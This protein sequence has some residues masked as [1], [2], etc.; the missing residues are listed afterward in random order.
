MKTD[1]RDAFIQKRGFIIYFFCNKNIL[2][3]IGNGDG[4]ILGKGRHGTTG[5]LNTSE[6]NIEILVILAGHAQP[7]MQNTSAF[8]WIHL[9]ETKPPT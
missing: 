5:V 4:N 8:R 3:R 6:K 1:F 9:Y 2:D 7:E